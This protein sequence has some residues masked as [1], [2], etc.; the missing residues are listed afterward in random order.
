GMVTLD[1]SGANTNQNTGVFTTTQGTLQNAGRAGNV[2]L[3]AGSLTLKSGGRIVSSTL[4]PGDAG[5]I[6]VAVAGTATLDGSAN[7]NSVTRISSDTL[8]SGAGGKAGAV[9]VSAAALSI[10]GG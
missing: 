10:K 1:G 2:T 4:G 6:S 3:S 5:A 7:P 8:S 9:A